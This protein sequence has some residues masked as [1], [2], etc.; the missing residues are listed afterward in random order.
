[1]NNTKDFTL[2]ERMRTA[3]VTRW[4]IINTSRPQ[5][6]AEHL[7]LVRTL[8]IAFCRAAGF[9]EE[10][11]RLAEQWAL[12]HDVPEVRTGDL[13]TPVKA[14]MREAVP[15]DDPIRRIELNMSDRYAAL[16]NRVKN[17]SPWVRDLVKLADLAEAIAFLDING[18]GRHARTA[19]AGLSKAFNNQ[20]REACAM[21][22][23]RFDWL[24]VHKLAFDTI[25]EMK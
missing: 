16:Y 1:M 11:T 25:D 15:H 5:S 18:C 3:H 2:A 12:E 4:Q 20:V 6:L 22:G 23:D 19:R 17:E 8:A 7:Y 14:A 24:A 9:S 10:D 21:Y 13:A